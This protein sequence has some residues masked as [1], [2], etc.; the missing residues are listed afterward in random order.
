[1]SKQFSPTLWD[2]SSAKSLVAA[3]YNAEPRT[4]F[5]DD[6]WFSVGNVSMNKAV[7]R[8]MLKRGWTGAYVGGENPMF[9]LSYC[10]ATFAWWAIGQGNQNHTSPMHYLTGGN[11]AAFC[12]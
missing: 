3:I 11:Y 7:Y 12:N 8:K 4:E 1:L 2:K 9:V 5:G 10:Q 6:E